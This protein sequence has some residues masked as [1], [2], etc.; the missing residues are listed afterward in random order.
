MR[1]EWVESR[2]KEG[3]AAA[4]GLV[5]KA[6]G[7]TLNRVA[8]RGGTAKVASPQPG[9]PVSV[10]ELWARRYERRDGVRCCGG[11]ADSSEGVRR[12]DCSL[13][14]GHT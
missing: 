3:D 14:I 1:G 12:A 7:R 2:R 10:W 8:T 4:L 6:G 11:V 9:L 13:A 5:V